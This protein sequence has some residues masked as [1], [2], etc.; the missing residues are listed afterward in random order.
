MKQKYFI[1]L[2]G[3]LLAAALFM[4]LTGLAQGEVVCQSDL[5]VQAGDFLSRI[6]ADTYGNPTLYPAIVDATNQKAETDSSYTRIDQ[7]D[8]IR[9]GW[10]LCLPAQPS[11]DKGA[12]EGEPVVAEEAAQSQVVTATEVITFTPGV[13]PTETQSGSC[14]TNAIAVDRAEAYRCTVGNAIYDPCFV[15]GETVICGADPAS[16]ETGFILELTDPLP[17]P[18]TAAESQPLPWLVELADGQICG[19]MTGTVAGVGDRLAP[20]GCPDGSYLFEDFQ[21][22]EIWQAEKAVIGLNEDGYYLEQ[23]EIVPIQR[24]WQ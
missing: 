12:D 1:A 13:T 21:P 20:Y 15:V 10:K 23:S 9:P 6:A 2:I 8:L 17:D 14:F 11:P 4:P 18:E 3:L 19:R 7:P 22:G 16:D 5:V 24:I